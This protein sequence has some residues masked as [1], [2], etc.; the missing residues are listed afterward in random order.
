VHR[1]VVEPRDRSPPSRDQS[2]KPGLV[3][4]YY[5]VVPARGG[6]LT[7]GMVVSPPATSFYKGGQVQIT[8]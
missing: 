5:G 8:V 3:G 7:T 4:M 1:H 6:A 2:S